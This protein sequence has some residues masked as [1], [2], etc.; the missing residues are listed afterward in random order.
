MDIDFSNNDSSA[1]TGSS[2]AQGGGLVFDQGNP[3][4]NTNTNMNG[5]LEWN[6]ANP[7]FGNGTQ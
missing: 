1:G 4:A 7:S 2:A 6:F 3:F 5:G